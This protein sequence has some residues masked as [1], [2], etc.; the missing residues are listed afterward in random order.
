MENWEFNMQIPSDPA[1]ALLKN[2]PEERKI[3]VHQKNYTQILISA[4]FIR[5]SNWE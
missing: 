1:T 3:Y 2:L 5:A 4:L